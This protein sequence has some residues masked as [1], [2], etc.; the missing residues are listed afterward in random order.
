MAK[1]SSRNRMVVRQWQILKT[2][3]ERPSTLQQLAFD[4]ETTVRTVRRDLEALAEAHFPL[5]MNRDDDGLRRW[6]LLTKG[7]APGR[8]VA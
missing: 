6:H 5:Y 8:R 4:F 1:Q 3:E 7:V 2:L